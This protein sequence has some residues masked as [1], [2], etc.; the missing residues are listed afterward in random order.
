MSLG[1]RLALLYPNEIRNK[2]CFGCAVSNEDSTVEI[3]AFI[4]GN[5]NVLQ[6]GLAD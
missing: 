1:G 5:L 3:L 6:L 2:P 4:L